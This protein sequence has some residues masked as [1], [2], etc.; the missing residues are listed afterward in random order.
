VDAREFEARWKKLVAD[1]ARETANVGC[2]GC[3]TCERCSDCTFCE[4]C[5]G[6]N[7]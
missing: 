3:E 7:R 4:R 5:T 6:T 2:I 1:R